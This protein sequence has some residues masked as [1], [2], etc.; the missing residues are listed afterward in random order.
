MEQPKGF[1]KEGKE[2]YVLKFKKA[3]NGLKQAPRA[4]NCKLNDTLKSMGFI[5]TASDQECILTVCFR[6]SLNH[7][8]FSQKKFINTKLTEIRHKI[9]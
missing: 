1:I 4:W 9:K 5:K 6:A 2:D 3:L 7:K 8:N